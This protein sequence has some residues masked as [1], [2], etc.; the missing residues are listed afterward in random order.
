[1]PVV[2]CVCGF[3]ASICAAMSFCMS[4]GSS[5]AEVCSCLTESLTLP[6]T[7]LTM[8]LARTYLLSD[9][10]ANSSAQTAHAWTYRYHLEKNLPLIADRWSKGTYVLNQL[11]PLSLH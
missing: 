7:A 4:H 1:M 5:S 2:L 8:R 11:L 9:L 10:L 6:D 3:R